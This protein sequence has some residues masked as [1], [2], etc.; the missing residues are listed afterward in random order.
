MFHQI[1]GMYIV[2]PK[3]SSK[4]LKHIQIIAFKDKTMQDIVEGFDLTCVQA[5]FSKSKV[6]AKA[7]LLKEISDN[8]KTTGVSPL[9]L[10]SQSYMEWFRTLARLEKYMY[11]G[12][13]VT[14]ETWEK[15][16]ASINTRINKEQTVGTSILF[17]LRML[18]NQHHFSRIKLD[19][20]LNHFSG[21]KLDNGPFKYSYN[22]L[23]FKT[24]R[25]DMDVPEKCFD[26]IDLAYVK[27]ENYLNNIQSRIVIIG[28]NNQAIGY[29]V[30]SFKNLISSP[31]SIFYP[32][33]TMNGLA[34]QQPDF[35]TA[36]VKVSMSDQN[37]YIPQMQAF[38]MVRKVCKIWKL[39]GYGKI[40]RSFSQTARDGDYMS[41]FH[42]QD[43]TVLDLFDA[44]PI[45]TTDKEYEYASK[46]YDFTKKST[47]S[48]GKSIPLN[49]LKSR[50]KL[51]PLAPLARTISMS[52]SIP[53]AP[54]VVAPAPAAPA[55]NVRPPS[56]RPNSS[57]RRPR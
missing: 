57:V 29:N 17:K 45:P 7:S 22:R 5:F 35:E 34:S 50:I 38:Q 30:D 14:H 44:H 1:D 21:I 13:S 11:R 25:P 47:I 37:L 42:C 8:T 24:E 32:C 46:E 56:S 15:V 31:T 26:V 23:I 4:D 43:R 40:Q 10:E 54:N 28:A 6:Y 27:I 41:A 19:G 49:P 18:P 39:V 53:E 48:L 12:F 51:P 9:A 52:Q 2:S 36:Y 16:I 3:D 20:P 33:L 55:T